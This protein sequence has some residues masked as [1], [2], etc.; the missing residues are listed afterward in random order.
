M[1]VQTTLLLIVA[2]C[3]ATP[4]LAQNTS[5]DDIVAQTGFTKQQV[6]MLVGA[7][8]PYPAYRVS[9]ERLRKELIAKVGQT[10]YDQ[11]VEDLQNQAELQRNSS[12]G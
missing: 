4:V 5:V 7:R 1:K 2:A 10:R 3:F 6:R 11:L 8:T 12:T 9:Y